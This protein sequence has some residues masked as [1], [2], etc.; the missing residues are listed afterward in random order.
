MRVA[1]LGFRAAAGEASLLAALH[2]AGLDGVEALATA[3]DK[4]AATALTGLAARLGLPVIAVDLA[5]LARAKVAGSS[6]SPARYGAQSVAE[7]AA[8]MAAGPGA[9]RVVA[10]MVSEDGMA[11]AAIAEGAGA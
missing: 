11:V 3:A 9:R 6:R 2:E 7:A 8:L 4:A 5:D 10:R 1:G